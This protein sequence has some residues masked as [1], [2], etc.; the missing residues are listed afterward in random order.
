[1]RS[2]PRDTRINIKFPIYSIPR[3]FGDS[4]AYE[5]WKFYAR[6]CGTRPHSGFCTDCLPA[7][8]D[9]MVQE[10]KC[11]YPEVVFRNNKGEVQGFFPEVIG[12]RFKELIEE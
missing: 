12:S 3:C 4:V 2:G 1:M 7:Y 8:K 6:N 10:N 9:R 5:E 11:H